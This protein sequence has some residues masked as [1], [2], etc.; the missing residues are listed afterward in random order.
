LRAERPARR[1]SA[2]ARRPQPGTLPRRAARYLLRRLARDRAALDPRYRRRVRH[3][4]V[5]RDRIQGGRIDR[6][7]HR[8]FPA[9]W[10]SRLSLIR[11]LR[12]AAPPP[13]PGRT[14]PPGTTRS[15]GSLFPEPA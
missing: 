8:R 11:W 6:P 13:R 14:A 15:V 9:P 12:H 4:A 1:R 3:G 2:A 5:L 10:Y 7:G